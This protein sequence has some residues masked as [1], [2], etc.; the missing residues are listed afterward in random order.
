MRVAALPLLGAALLMTSAS[1]APQRDVLIRPGVGIGEVRLGMTLAQVKA[2][3]GRHDNGWSERRGFGRRYLELVWDR[4]PGDFTAVGLL[5]RPGSLRV[6]TV[7][8][9]RRSERTPAGV[10]PGTTIVRLR[11]VYPRA[12][13][14]LVWPAGGGTIVRSEYVLG[15]A[16]GP[17][18]SFVVRKWNFYDDADDV[19]WVVYVDVRS[20]AFTEDVRYEP[21]R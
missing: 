16:G 7:G 18:T 21:C 3:L 6:V 9:T 5:G 14:R 12:R 17:Q 4:G 19:P 11:R 10:G 20:P 13:C 8:T 1:G 2:A 15:A